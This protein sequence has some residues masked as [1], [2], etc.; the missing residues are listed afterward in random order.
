[1][2]ICFS[3]KN[4]FNHRIKNNNVGLTP[5]PPP[6]RYITQLAQTAAKNNTHD[7]LG[8]VT[9]PIKEISGNNGLDEWYTL[10]VLYASHNLPPAGM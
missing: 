7:F 1:M 8:M 3:F 2:N 5:P 9:V 4:R 6:S 10:Q